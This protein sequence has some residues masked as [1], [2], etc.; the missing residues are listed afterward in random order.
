MMTEKSLIF[1]YASYIHT[2]RSFE[3]P[4]PGL[5]PPVVTES[6]FHP[7]ITECTVRRV[8]HISDTQ[9]HPSSVDGVIM[10]NVGDD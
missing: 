10:K 4:F 8:D 7:D 2:F 1:N 3:T 5:P 9:E 6:G